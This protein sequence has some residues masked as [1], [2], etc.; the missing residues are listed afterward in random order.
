M[1]TV[2]FKGLTVKLCASDNDA[3]VMADMTTAFKPA[4]NFTYKKLQ[5][6]THMEC[7]L[8][9]ISSIIIHSTSVQNTG[10]IHQTWNCTN[11]KPKKLPTWRLTKCV[12][13]VTKW[14][15]NN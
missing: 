13:C 15:L 11:S 9:T 12:T 4:K 2:G 8:K 5:Q 1:A 10:Q 6:L 7:M 3:R 14:N